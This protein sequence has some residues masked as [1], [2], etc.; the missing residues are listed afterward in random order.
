MRSIADA[1]VGAIN[2]CEM[3]SP[4]SNGSVWSL[5]TASRGEFACNVPMPGRPELSAMS[6]S[7]ASASRTSPTI[8]RDGLIRSDSLIRRRR[9]ISPSP[10]RF[11]LRVCICTT[12]GS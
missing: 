9:G 8:M 3:F 4:A 6:R 1:T 11:A 10:C 7:K 5:I 12:S 2:L